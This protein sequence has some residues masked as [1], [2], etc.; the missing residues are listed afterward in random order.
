MTESL[1]NQLY[2]RYRPSFFS[3][4]RKL[5]DLSK[6]ELEDLYQD[7]FISFCENVQNGR[8][9]LQSNT[10]VKSYLF[11]IGK[12]K[13]YNQLRNQSEITE[14][15]DPADSYFAEEPD[16]M[17]AQAEEITY[18]F[19]QTIDHSCRDI[20]LLYY[21]DRLRMEEIARRLNLKNEQVAKNK[22]SICLRKIKSA[23][24][25]LLIENGIEL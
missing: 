18:E 8:F 24:K 23:L 14:S 3:F 10:S 22:K 19:I 21:W 15:I 12:F 16:C 11:Q 7:T 13:Y 4:M 9:T 25:Q 6:E 17:Q 5:G 20:L 2:N 1:I